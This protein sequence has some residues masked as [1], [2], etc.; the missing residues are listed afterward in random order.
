MKTTDSKRRQRGTAVVELAI[1]LPL[2]VFLALMICE[3]SEFLRVHQVINNA[4]REG[5]RLSSLP[6]NENRTAD[7]VAR[8]QSYVTANLNADEQNTP[9]SVSIDQGVWITTASGVMVRLS[10]VTV[11]YPYSLQFLPGLPF[12]GGASLVNLNAEADFRNL[13]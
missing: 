1:V 3:G 10:R 13:Y 8:V 11:E 6:E 7:I 12:Y 2:M 9:I 4:A 5:A